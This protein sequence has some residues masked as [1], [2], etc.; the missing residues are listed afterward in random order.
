M[1]GF[2]LTHLYINPKRKAFPLTV[3]RYLLSVI[4]Y[5]LAINQNH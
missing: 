2:A 3:I 1:E 4:Q 5:L